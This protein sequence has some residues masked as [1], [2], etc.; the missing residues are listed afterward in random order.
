MTKLPTPQSQQDLECSAAWAALPAS[1]YQSAEAL[2]RNS[3]SRLMRT[4]KPQRARRSVFTEEEDDPICA[5]ELLYQVPATTLTT[6]LCPS[7]ELQQQQ[8]LCQEGTGAHVH[9]CAAFSVPWVISVK[10]VCSKHPSLHSATSF[11][12]GLAGVLDS[13]LYRGKLAVQV[14]PL[15]LRGG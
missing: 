15:H 8:A 11:A 4:T 13:N 10:L 9:T 7:T 12:V 1:P 3:G 6:R 2:R 5:A 14:S